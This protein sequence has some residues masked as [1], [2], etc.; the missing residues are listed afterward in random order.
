LK[1]TTIAFLGEEDDSWRWQR[2]NQY[3]YSLQITPK[4]VIRWQQCHLRLWYYYQGGSYGRWRLKKQHFAW[5]LSHARHYFAVPVGGWL[6][7]ALQVHY[8]ESEN[9]VPAARPGRP[10]RGCRAALWS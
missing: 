10:W 9:I 1:Q 4:A 2:H 8:P 5:G 7:I 6:E 3:I